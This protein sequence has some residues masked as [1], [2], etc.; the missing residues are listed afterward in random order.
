MF[1]R[2]AMYRQHW[3]HPESLPGPIMTTPARF[4]FTMS[5]KRTMASTVNLVVLMTKPR[6]GKLCV[7]FKFTKLT[8]GN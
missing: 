8:I 7:N 6:T 1:S 5:V 2:D 3:G 4:Y